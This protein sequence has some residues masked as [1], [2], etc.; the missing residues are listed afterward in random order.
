M[1]VCVCFAASPFANRSGGAPVGARPPRPAPNARR[2]RPTA[3]SHRSRSQ[4][5]SDGRAVQ[6]E[7]EGIFFFSVSVPM[8]STEGTQR[9]AG[10]RTRDQ[11]SHIWVPPHL[12]GHPSAADIVFAPVAAAILSQCSSPIS[13]PSLRCWDPGG[14][15]SQEWLPPPQ[16]PRSCFSLVLIFLLFFFMNIVFINFSH[17]R[18]PQRC[19]GPDHFHAH[20]PTLPWKTITTCPLNATPAVPG[21]A[22]SALPSQAPWRAAYIPMPGEEARVF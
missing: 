6:G 12:C 20:K 4:R 11:R 2:G 1:H 13:A 8:G 3:P 17:G 9:G 10:H 21:L 14:V 19:G 16:G 22:R 15:A 5:I 18:G 7:A